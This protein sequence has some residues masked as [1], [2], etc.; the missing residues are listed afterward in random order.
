MTAETDAVTATARLFF[1]LW[2]PAGVADALHATARSCAGCAVAVP[3]A[4]DADGAPR[5][6]RSSGARVMQPDTLH[7]TLAFLGEVPLARLDALRALAARLRLPP[8]VL[9]LDRLGY[10][11]APRIV[12]A[13]C[14]TLPAPLARLAGELDG[15]LRGAG[16]ALPDR[17]FAPHVTLLRGVPPPGPAALPSPPAIIWPVAGFV[18]VV[19]TPGAST[20]YRVLGHWPLHGE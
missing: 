16:F 14:A 9:T 13:G 7:L 20:N 8:F 5:A 11:P 18:L 17:P 1:A 3:A 2:P 4:L 19:S 6:S 10:W 15:A 12:W